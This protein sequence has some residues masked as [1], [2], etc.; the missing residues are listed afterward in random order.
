MSETDSYVN[1]HTHLYSALVPLGMPAP[2][3]APANF[4]ETLKSIWWRLDRAL[5]ADSLRASARLY[6]AEAVKLG[7][8][9]VLDHHESPRFIEGSLDVIAD[10]CQELGLRAVV[11]YGATERNDGRGEAQRGLKECRRFIESNRRP[12]VRGVVGLHAGFTVSDDTI[13]DAANLARDLGSVLHLHVAEDDVDVRDARERGYEGII[14]RL[15]KLDALI[16]GSVFAH[17]IHL[18]VGGSAALRGHGLLVRSEPAIES[19]QRARLPQGSTPQRPRGARHRRLPGRHAGRGGR[20]VHGGGGRP[21]RSRSCARAALGGPPARHRALFRLI[22]GGSAG[23]RSGLGESAKSD[24]GH[25][26]SREDPGRKGLDTNA[27]ALVPTPRAI[28]L[29]SRTAAQTREKA[30]PFDKKFWI[31]FAAVLVVSM[32]L[33]FVVHGAIL[34]SDYEELTSVMRPAAEQEARF[35]FMV[36][37]HFILAFGLAWL[38]R[39]GR[40]ARQA[41]AGSGSALRHRV[42]VGSV[43]ADLSHLSHGGAVPARSGLEAGRAGVSELDRPGSDAGIRQQVTING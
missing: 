29:F 2:N 26:S 40:D 7:T 41:L 35:G 24:T 18:S 39:G 28:V 27:S 8:Y 16:P 37:A 31:S 32:L 43:G 9:A 10:A 13:R 30:M 15:E 20:P 11:C 6:A 17:G 22:A 42:R 23:P 14:H 12:L 36:G 4:V 34:A 33:G 19:R 3:P 25:P 21:R 1:A 5:D 38:Y